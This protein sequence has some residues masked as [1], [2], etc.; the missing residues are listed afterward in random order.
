MYLDAIF[1]RIDRDGNGFISLDE[2]IEYIPPNTGTRNL[3]AREIES[4]ARMML[5]EADTNKDGQISREEF[6]ALMKNTVMPD[7]LEQ[8]EPRIPDKT[9]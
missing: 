2:L 5:R 7:T 4:Q 1:A 6:Y 9:K 3:S 8:Y